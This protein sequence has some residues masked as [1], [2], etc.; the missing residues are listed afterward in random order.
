MPLSQSAL[1]QHL[2]RLRAEELVAA[3]RDGTRMIYRLA[4]PEARRIVE[5]LHGLYCAA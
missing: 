2:A 5:V 1:S 4:S 3:E